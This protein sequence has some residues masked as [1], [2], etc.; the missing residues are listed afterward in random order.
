MKHLT[1]A[2]KFRP[3]TQEVKLLYRRKLLNRY[4]QKP[5][6]PLT[7]LTAPTGFG[8]S[9]LLAQWAEGENSSSIVWVNLS[10]SDEKLENFIK[11]LQNGYMAMEI[12]NAKT[13]DCKATEEDSNDTPPTT[14]CFTDDFTNHSTPLVIVLDNFQHINNREICQY[15]EDTLLYKSDDL[16]LIIASRERPKLN[17]SQPRLKGHVTDIAAKDL[18]FS[19]DEVSEF[20]EKNLTEIDVS[21][22]L[23]RTGGFV[24][25]LQLIKLWWEKEGNESKSIGSFKIHDTYIY[26]YF[27][28]EIAQNL[29]DDELKFLSKL[30]I[31]RKFNADIAGIITKRNDAEALL[32]QLER[33]APFISETTDSENYYCFHPLFRE[34]LKS[35]LA[36]YGNDHYKALHKSATAYFTEH[37][38]VFEAMRHAC[39]IGENNTAAEI[40]IQRGGGMRLFIR[41]GL[42]ALRMAMAMLP[43][44]IINKYP[45]LQLA[46]IVILMKDG[47]VI[48]GKK[49]L[50]ALKAATHNFSF[51]STCND[52]ASLYADSIIVEVLYRVYLGD[53]GNTDLINYCNQILDDASDDPITLSLF[54]QTIKCVVYLQTGSFDQ[55]ERATSIAEKLCRQ[56]KNY[57]NWAFLY[58]YMGNA[59]Y[60]KGLL[61]KSLYHYQ[62]GL[63]LLKKELSGE[64]EINAMLQV[65]MAEVYFEQNNLT[66]ASS[67]LHSN[68]DRVGRT[69]GWFDIYASGFKT[70][71]GLEIQN[72]GLE[73]AL[74]VLNRARVISSERGVE[75]LNL[76]IDIW[77]LDFK[78]RT[79]DTSDINALIKKLDLP[80]RWPMNRSKKDT[81]WRVNDDIALVASKLMLSQDQISD[82]KEVLEILIEDASK[83][84]RMG[85][86]IRA[87]LQMVCLYLLIDDQDL[88]YKELQKII[89]IASAEKIIMPFLEVR[90]AWATGL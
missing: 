49:R 7:L 70:A 10:K 25:A 44:E 54:L 48:Q 31:L 65:F 4:L 81:S 22:L 36:S 13:K 85:T 32:K 89:V 41:K 35:Y 8:K 37:G 52:I 79:R 40:L 39:K 3:P 17:L 2:I 19:H 14:K 61:N 20:I 68:L 88:A 42:N 53:V 38:Q 58:I 62:Q 11:S 59:E 75:K 63:H 77:E 29:T 26:D 18:N 51:D 16:S 78:L 84:G 66:Q 9:T 45:R 86:L 33:M 15:I 56:Q 82:A 73:G 6:K 21:E 46:Q 57:F 5:L 83:C 67:R 1:T 90:E 28:Y 47:F 30:S 60:A 76:L 12:T 64:E 34:Y 80:N 43:Q 24:A 87:T 55:V 69:E 74:A 50:D 71:A 27:Q 23:S 72:S